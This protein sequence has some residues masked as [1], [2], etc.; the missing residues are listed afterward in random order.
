MKMFQML[1][2][3]LTLCKITLFS[4]CHVILVT[5]NA[6]YGMINWHYYCIT[7]KP[8]CIPWCVQCALQLGGT[9]GAGGKDSGGHVVI[10][11]GNKRDITDYVLCIHRCL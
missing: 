1:F 7:I 10:D 11:L 9:G 3:P 2:L 5:H 4:A 6:E 8:Y